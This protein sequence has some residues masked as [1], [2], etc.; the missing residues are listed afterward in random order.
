M[1]FKLFGLF[2]QVSGVKESVFG[3]KNQNFDPAKK[4]PPNLEKGKKSWRLYSLPLCIFC[5]EFYHSAMIY[6]HRWPAMVI[7]DL[8]WAICM[9]PNLPFSILP[10]KHE[11]FL[12]NN[13]FIWFFVERCFRENYL[14]NAITVYK[15]CYAQ[16]IQL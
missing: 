6:F 5:I 4:L 10:P 8:D 11:L 9:S 3:V 1:I 2:S 12:E 14:F 15:N 7:F 16:Y 13:Y